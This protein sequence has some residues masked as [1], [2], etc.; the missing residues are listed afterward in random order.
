MT[1]V[2]S[3]PTAT[4]SQ[5]RGL[6]THA[7]SGTAPYANFQVGLDDIM[8]A[9][10]VGYYPEA[11]A[12]V[13]K[14]LKL[15]TNTALVLGSGGT[16]GIFTATWSGGNF[17]VNPSARFKVRNGRVDWFVVDGPGLCVNASPTAPTVSLSASTGLTGATIPLTIDVLV[18]SGETWWGDHAS[19]ATLWQ[20][21]RNNVGTAAALSGRTEPKSIYDVTGAVADGLADIDAAKQAG[22]D[23]LAAAAAPDVKE[24]PDRMAMV[25]ADGYLQ[26]EITPS[27]IRHPQMD[28][29]AAE[30]LKLESADSAEG[31]AGLAGVGTDGYKT[32]EMSP[33]AFRHPAFDP[34]RARSERGAPDAALADYAHLAERIGLHHIGQSLSVG[35]V[36]TPPIST[37]ASL[38]ADMFN[39]GAVP[40]VTNT[41]A[42][43]LT[44]RA[45]LTGLLEST[46]TGTAATE[47]GET[48]LSGMVEMI[49]QLLRDEDRLNPLD[50]GQKFIAASDGHAGSGIAGMLR[51]AETSTYVSQR[52][53]ASMTQGA[54]L[55]EAAGKSFVPGAIAFMQ[56]ETDNANNVTYAYYLAKL[57]EVQ[58][59]YQAYSNAV[60]GYNRP[61]PF[62]IF[63]TATHRVNSLTTPNV[64]LAQLAACASAPFFFAGPAYPV[65]QASS[66]A[67]Y[68]LSNVGSKWMGAYFGLAIKRLLFDQVRP[69]PLVPVIT[70]QGNNILA[71][72]PVGAGRRILGGQTSAD[73]TVL[74]DW[75]VTAVTAG[76]T[77]KTLSNPRI[78]GRDL[79]VWDA[80]ETPADTWKF[81]AAYT[82]N[83][84]KGWTNI[85]D[86]NPLIFDPDR[87]RLKMRTWVPICEVTLK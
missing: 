39:G 83:T 37:T 32:Y 44:N 70:A 30:V 31:P 40:D 34:V 66:G 28:S 23:A 54:G 80:P 48:A 43:K 77:A 4:G 12:Q 42:D 46:R 57:A 76:G 59:E 5:L 27:R 1:E 55:S 14:G 15:D 26:W 45:S 84:A 3:L 68:H 49:V 10:A 63:Q 78:A 69:A 72:F 82:G 71:R 75:G 13:P 9:S 11:T 24:G 87:L 20:L 73:T 61:L 47:G 56:G 53:E 2:T 6:K 8:A 41:I 51:S 64:A 21:Y 85:C 16:D 79:I 22:L 18:P 36:S 60:M 17:T 35:Y 67:Q 50:L 38:Y 62:F 25:G 74:S 65:P 33:T 52:L 58:A 29:H 81:R 86:D 19:D 7:F